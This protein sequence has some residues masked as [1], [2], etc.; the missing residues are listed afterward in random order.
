MWMTT[1]GSRQAQNVSVMSLFCSTWTQCDP[2]PPP[3]TLSPAW[4]TSVEWWWWLIDIRLFQ[5]NNVPSVFIL[6]SEVALQ[7][8]RLRHPGSPTGRRWK[9]TPSALPRPPDP[10]AQR[11]CTH[12]NTHSWVQFCFCRV[13]TNHWIM[14]KSVRVKTLNE[15]LWWWWTCHSTSGVAVATL[16]TGPVCWL[17]CSQQS[18]PLSLQSAPHS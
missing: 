13:Y 2:P 14:N 5:I 18:P 6:H 7:R 15:P 16:S 4:W 3:P 8:P 17:A 12:R 1:V 9:R 11:V 10:A